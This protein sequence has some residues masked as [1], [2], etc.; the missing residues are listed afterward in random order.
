M[1][2]SLMRQ[3]LGWGHWFDRH[4]LTMKQIGGSGM[5]RQHASHCPCMED[6]C[7]CV[8]LL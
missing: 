2:I 4:K 1:P 8:S 7:S 3:H 5:A 6:L